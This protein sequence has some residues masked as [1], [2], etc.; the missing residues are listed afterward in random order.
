M[1]TTSMSAKVER[2]HAI[3]AAVEHVPLV[4]K[5]TLRSERS[6]HAQRHF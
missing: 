1:M 5:Q 6:L 4:M 3:G 2:W